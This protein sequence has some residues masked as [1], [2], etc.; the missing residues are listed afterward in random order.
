MKVNHLIRSIYLYV[1][2]LIGLV[3]VIVSLYNFI[4]VGLR[5]TV[6]KQAQEPWTRCS[7]SSD[8]TVA[9]ASFDSA[10]NVSK[11]TP[12]PLT[13]EEK[14]TKKAEQ[15]AENQKCLVSDRQR[16]MSTNISV[17]IV[18]LPVFLYHWMLARK[19]HNKN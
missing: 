17:F 9:P 2:T 11:S 15:E 16:R 12:T 18:G 14:A 10:G 5:I 7:A 13:E 8:L 3:M 1:A 6:F 4:D 19:E